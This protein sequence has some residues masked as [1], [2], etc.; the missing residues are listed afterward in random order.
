[1]LWRYPRFEVL[2]IGAAEGPPIIAPTVST[3]VPFTGTYLP[4]LCRS[5]I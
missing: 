5:L 2:C 1:M 3:A 4:A